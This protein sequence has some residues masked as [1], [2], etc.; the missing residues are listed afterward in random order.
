MDRMKRLKKIKIK[1]MQIK[2]IKR[3]FLLLSGI[4][5]PSALIIA[6]TRGHAGLK[7]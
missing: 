6:S 2:K 3:F 5:C 7:S 4:S 1:R